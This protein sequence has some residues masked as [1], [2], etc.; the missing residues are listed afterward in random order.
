MI[1]Y[2]FKGD[3]LA[4]GLFLVLPILDRINSCFTKKQ[5]TTRPLADKNEKQPAPFSRK[6]NR[7]KKDN[8]NMSGIKDESSEKGFSVQTNKSHGSERNAKGYFR[9]VTFYVQMSAAMKITIEFSDVD[10]SKSVLDYISDNIDRALNFALSDITLKFCPISDLTTRGKHISLMVFLFA[11]Y[12]IWGI[13]CAIIASAWHLSRKA[14]MTMRYKL[15]NSLWLRFIGGLVEIIKYTYEGFCEVIFMSLVC[16]EINGKNVWWCDATQVCLEGWQIGMLS[17]GVVYALP[18]PLTLYLSMKRLEQGKISPATFFICCLCPLLGLVILPLCAC[19]TGKSERKPMSKTKDIILYTLQGPFRKDEKHMT[20]YWESIISVRRLLVTGMMLLGYAS[21]R[22]VILTLLCVSFLLHHT[23]RM[24]FHVR[25]SNHIESLSLVFL[26]SFAMF[27][28]LKA[29]LTDN[30]VIPV[31]PSV[32][33]FKALEFTEKL[34]P[35]ILVVVI[36][37][38]ELRKKVKGKRKNQ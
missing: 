1:W 6:E 22:M 3:I 19:C 11:I 2:T 5:A 33:F 24:P 29:S 18:F 23:Y 16:I 15:L 31:G 27:N 7:F 25:T 9:I 8:T 32:G 30:G 13:L 21:I 36:V 14:V 17:F 26:I 35:I 20:L 10:D 38:I 34:F 28:L 12:I 4:F 37:L